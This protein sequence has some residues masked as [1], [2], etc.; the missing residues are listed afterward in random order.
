MT[1]KRHT[2]LYVGV[3]NDLKRKAH[4][5][6]NSLIKGFTKR[7]NVCELVYYEVCE[8]VSGAIYREK[9]IKGGSRADKIE[10]I[11]NMNPDWHDFY[12]E[13]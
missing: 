1:N 4:E 6:R 5:H 12:E 7:Y 8:D 2:V 9:Q 13:I 11:N 10:L 3:T